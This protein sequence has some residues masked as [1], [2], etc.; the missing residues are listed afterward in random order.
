M[1]CTDAFVRGALLFDAGAFFEAHEA[2]EE[3]WRVESDVTRRRCLQ[4][5][6]QIAAAFHKLFVIRSPLA[7]SS[8]LAK[9]LEKLDACPVSVGGVN[10]A[11]FREG[12]RACVNAGALGH[13]DRAAVPQIGGGCGQSG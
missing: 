7:A 6:I 4:G 3:M 8:L 9:G 2:W 5:L 12:L 1:R 10:L 11:A 13:F